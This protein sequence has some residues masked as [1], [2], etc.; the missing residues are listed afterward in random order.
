M[1]TSVW[2]LLIRCEDAISTTGIWAS[3]RMARHYPFPFSFSCAILRSVSSSRELGWCTP[4]T[5]LGP[6]D[7]AQVV[8]ARMR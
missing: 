6:L 7:Q 3:C 8:N 5:V 2:V 4:N 1:L